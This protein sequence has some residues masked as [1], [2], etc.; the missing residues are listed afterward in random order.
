MESVEKNL[1]TV[2]EKVTQNELQFTLTEDPLNMH[3]SA[4]N[5]AAL[6]SKVS[7]IN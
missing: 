3:R 4:T 2:P 7:I 6:V 1:E 5:K